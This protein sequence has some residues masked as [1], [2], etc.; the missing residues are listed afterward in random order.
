MKN[1]TLILLS[2][3][4][5]GSCSNP[6]PTNFSDINISDVI[7]GD[8][9]FYYDDM[10][11]VVNESGI[12]D[13][14]ILEKMY[15]EM[16][17]DKNEMYYA[18]VMGCGSTRLY[19]L[20]HDTIFFFYNSVENLQPYY[21]QTIEYLNDD[22]LL[23]KDDTTEYIIHRIPEPAY[24]VSDEMHYRKKFRHL[25]DPDK[26]MSAL[27]SNPENYHAW[28]QSR[29]LLFDVLNGE[30]DRESALERINSVLASDYN[31]SKDLREYNKLVKKEIKKIK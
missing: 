18:D 29:K 20:R 25:T 2:L 15:V 8:W 31:A 10:V 4:L 21:V 17:F 5:L 30:Q 26:Y 24:T 28:Y 13:T 14:T 27:Q 7:I 23:F 19:D 12:T 9:N 16:S 22:A 11:D 1:I 6:E 3:I